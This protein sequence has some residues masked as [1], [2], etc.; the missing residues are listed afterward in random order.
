MTDP[1]TIEQ[2]R[3]GGTLGH[4]IRPG[5]RVRIYPDG[6][7][8]TVAYISATPG[9]ARPVVGVDTGDGTPETEP[10]IE[11]HDP[12]NLRKIFPPDPGLAPG[13]RITWTAGNGTVRTGTILSWAEYTGTWLVQIHP[14]G[15]LYPGYRTWFRPA[16]L[17]KATDP[18]AT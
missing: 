17:V 16:D 5:D 4:T 14:D 6:R 9:H 18:T 11:E 13:D 10:N 3:D 12:Y 2:T 8:G 7:Y 1:A 15:S